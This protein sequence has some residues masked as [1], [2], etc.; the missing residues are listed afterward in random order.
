MTFFSIQ[1]SRD[2]RNIGYA[3]LAS[4]GLVILA[5]AVPLHYLA[6]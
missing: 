1:M 5:A 3:F 6:S 4:M 2:T